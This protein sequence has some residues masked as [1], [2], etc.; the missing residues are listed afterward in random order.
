MGNEEEPS[1]PAR[2][3]GRVK[4]GVGVAHVFESPLGGWRLF[5]VPSVARGMQRYGGDGWM[6]LRGREIERLG[7]NSTS[8]HGSAGSDVLLMQEG[9]TLCQRLPGTASGTGR[10]TGEEI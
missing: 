9:R 5:L 1:D 4:L 10:R 8:Q 7:E 3:E 2:H 6:S